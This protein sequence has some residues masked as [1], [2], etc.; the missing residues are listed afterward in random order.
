MTTI[1]DLLAVFLLESNRIEGIHTRPTLEDVDAFFAFL[2]DPLT[3]SSVLSYQAHIAPGKPL[4]DKEGMDVR[5]GSHVAPPGGGSIK[6]ELDTLLSRI[7]SGKK[8]WTPYRAHCAFE[9]LHPFLDGNGRTGRA[10]WAW[11]MLRRGEYPFKLP[12]LH[13]FY[14]QTLEASDGR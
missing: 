6:S 7:R 11:H 14:Y 2:K 1:K 13:R 9:T 8:G 10:V 5:V 12:F 4:R 3:L